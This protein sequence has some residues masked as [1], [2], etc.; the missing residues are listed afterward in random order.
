MKKWAEEEDKKYSFLYKN[1]YPVGSPMRLINLFNIDKNKKCID[2]GCGRASLSKYFSQYTGI[3]VSEY[4]IKNN[5]NNR[6]GLFYHKSLDELYDLTENYDVAICSDVME[7]IPENEIDNTLK[8]ISSLQV[9]H[10]YFAIST[11]KSVLLDANGNNLHLSILT[12]SKWIDYLSNYFQIINK[13]V[14]PTLFSV[15]CITKN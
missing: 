14:K 11:R 10:Y 5:L 12:A 13:E 8:S 7:H 9:Q 6:Q 2:L 4:I 3:D 15:K 1:N